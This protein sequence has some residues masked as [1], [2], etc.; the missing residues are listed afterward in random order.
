[1]HCNSSNRI[2][3]CKKAHFSPL[4]ENMHG[5]RCVSIALIENIHEKKHSLLVLMENMEGGTCPSHMPNVNVYLFFF[6]PLNRLNIQKIHISYE[7][8]YF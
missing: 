7:D 4:I 8:L 1:V 3:A 2:Y 6:I 5:G